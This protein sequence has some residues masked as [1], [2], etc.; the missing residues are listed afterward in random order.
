MTKPP[1]S[2]IIP[3]MKKLSEEHKRKI[4]E[5][6]RG[7]KRPYLAE[8]NKS[9]WMRKKVSASKLGK[10][11]PDISGKNHYRWNGG[12]SI[13][14]GRKTIFKPNHPFASNHGY[15]LVYRLIIEK[16]I[17]R[18]LKPEEIIHHKDEDRTNNNI[19]NLQIMTNSEHISHH[20]KKRWKDPEYR[21]KMIKYNK[22]RPRDPKTGKLI[23][24]NSPLK[25][26]AKII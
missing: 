19:E 1:F 22:L 25:S 6:N 5:A 7:K 9:L 11:R 20:M 21:K 17:G 3:V 24:H 13:K 4:G 26:L 2:A 10:K 18:Y 12:I 14:Q 15:V 23:S 8:R 16:H